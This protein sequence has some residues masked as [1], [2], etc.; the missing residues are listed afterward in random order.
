[1]SMYQIPLTNACA[2][3]ALS[4][5]ALKLRNV[6]L[7]DKVSGLAAPFLTGIASIIMMLQPF[8]S[9][10]LSD[11]SFAPIVMAGLR[12]GWKTAILSSLLPGAYVYMFPQEDWLHLVFQEMFI[13]AIV[14]SLFHRAEYE[15]GYSVI[16]M[17]D[18]LYI[19]L[20]LT[21]ARILLHAGDHLLASGAFWLSQLFMFGVSGAAI[22]VLV[23]MFNEENRTWMLQRKLELEANQ[24][25]LTRLPN[26]RGFLDIAGRTI[27]SRRVA[28]LMIDIDNFKMFND[29]FGH[30]QGDQL[31][32]EVGSILR[33]TIDV[34]DYV[35]RYGGEEFIILSHS[36]DRRALEAYAQRL[37]DAVAEYPFVTRD[38]VRTTISIGI[39]LA[40]TAQADLTQL[41]AEADEALYE[42]K[43]MG[44]NRYTMY[45]K[46]I[47]YHEFP[48]VSNETK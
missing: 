15:N 37:C 44:K 25:G 24:D 5:I 9:E 46:H 47:S 26:L 20:L 39:S 22:A 19:C 2:L 1:M 33:G 45:Q 36:T 13:P 14:S 8:P 43:F 27:R 42:S 23:Y 31:L 6:A 7:F 11:L 12:F 35:A 16:R 48:P 29:T 32:R 34:Q 10:L 28:I 40:R 3:I 18:G 41:I 30:L 4:Y 21:V 38:K 17:T